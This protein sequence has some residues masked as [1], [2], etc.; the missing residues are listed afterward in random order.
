MPE[1][2]NPEFEYHALKPGPV[3]HDL[4]EVSQLLKLHV[5]LPDGRELD[6]HIDMGP[7]TLFS[8]KDIPTEALIVELEKRFKKDES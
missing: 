6:Y 5:T 8:M 2:L 7:L 4:K 3:P 1:G